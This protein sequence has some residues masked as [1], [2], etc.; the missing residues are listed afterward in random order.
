MP[1]F[2]HSL[3]V[4]SAICA[5]VVAVVFVFALYSTRLG[6]L[7]ARRG[8]RR[9]TSFFNNLSAGLSAFRSP[10]G[11]AVAFG[12]S[13]TPILCLS[14]GYGQWLQA[15]SAHGGL[16]SGVLVLGAMTLGQSTLGVP[17]AMGTS[18]VV[19][20]WSARILGVGEEDA[21]AFSTLMT[22]SSAAT[23]TVL[24]LISLMVGSVRWEDLRRP[25][26]SPAPN[27]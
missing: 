3:S 2:A 26:A 21:A 23:Y 9:L 27:A 15:L 5:G 19:A 22:L 24:G 14:L 4:A 1:A 11:F 7:A 20:T 12:L 13:S 18:F 10:K 16:A 6:E 25:A 8:W 17:A